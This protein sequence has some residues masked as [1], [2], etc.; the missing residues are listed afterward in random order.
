MATLLKKFAKPP[1]SK[2]LKRVPQ[3]R[4]DKEFTER[5]LAAISRYVLEWQAKASALGLTEGEIE[6]IREDH[7]NSNEVQKIAMLRRWAQKYGDKATLRELILIS[8]RNKWKK[9]IHQVCKEL[10]YPL[11]GIIDICMH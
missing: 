7:R 4:L 10:G 9:F 2:I 8:G 5:E 6:D 3:E 11:K 1:I